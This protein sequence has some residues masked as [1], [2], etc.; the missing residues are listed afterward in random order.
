MSM[1][2]LVCFNCGNGFERSRGE[3]NRS[4]K[5]GRKDFCSRSCSVS[6]SNRSTK[7]GNLDNL[8]AGNL[9]DDYTPFRWFLARARAR[10]KKHGKHNL[11]LEFLSDLW[12]AQKGLCAVSGWELNLPISTAGFESKRDPKN[13]SL[14][15]I[16]STKGYLKGN[17]RFISLAANYAMKEWPDKV[18]YEFCEA[19]VSHRAKA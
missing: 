7:R 16:D 17:V 14:D 15:R 13:A 5:L 6:A 11:T 2:S 4:W 12:E 1:V 19:V 10:N 8:D 18:L 3:V 9:R